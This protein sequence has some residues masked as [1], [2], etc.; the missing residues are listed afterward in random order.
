[1]SIVH[2]RCE[3]K[4]L[5]IKILTKH[6]S[7]VLLLCF[8]RICM[9]KSLGMYNVHPS[10]LGKLLVTTGEQEVTKLITRSEIIDLSNEICH[11]S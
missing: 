6:S 11:V 3:A 4:D 8:V 9:N 10:V 5:F 2:L 1:M 7:S